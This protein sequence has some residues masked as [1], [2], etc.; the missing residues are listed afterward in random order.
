MSSVHD[1]ETRQAF[2]FGRFAYT[3]ESEI[4]TL[5][6]LNDF[7][8]ESMDPVSIPNET[9]VLEAISNS[10]AEELQKFDCSIDEDTRLLESKDEKLTKNIRNCIIMRR[11]EK[12]VLEYFILMAPTLIPLLNMHWEKLKKIVPKL[13]PQQRKYETYINQVVV[14]LVMQSS[15]TDP[16]LTTD[17]FPENDIELTDAF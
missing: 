10:S 13:T 2:S 3:I 8:V 16:F 11:G 15:P 7:R 4:K 9:K 17:F 14:P 1:E 6:S 12:E 5:S